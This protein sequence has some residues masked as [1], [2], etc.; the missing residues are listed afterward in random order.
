ME[1]QLKEVLKSQMQWTKCLIAESRRL[2]MLNGG[3][4]YC[5]ML[6]GVPFIAPRELG[7]IGAPFGRPL[8]LLSAGAPD[9][10]VHIEQWTVRPLDATENHLIG[11]FPLLWGTG[12]SSVPC[13]RWPEANVAASRCTAGALDCPASHADCLV[14]F[15]QR[16]LKNP[17]VASLAGPCTV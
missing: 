6:L 17:R 16:R 10:P 3:L 15:S 8:L 7:A 1:S 13:D 9:Y 14:I 12:L 2:R 5:S 4:V 11:W